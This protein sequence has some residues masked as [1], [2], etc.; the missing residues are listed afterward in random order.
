[1]NCS[2]P[3]SPVLHCLP[4]F[5][6]ED[7]ILIRCQYSPNGLT[8]WVQPLGF[9]EGTSGEEAVCQC[10]RCGSD[11]WVGKIPWGR[12]WQPTPVFLPGKPHGQRHGL[13]GCSPQGHK[14]VRQGWATEHMQSL[15]KCKPD[16]R[17]PETTDLTMKCIWKWKGHK[18]AK[19]VF[20]R[21][22]VAEFTVSNC[23]THNKATAV[24]TACSG[25]KDW[26]T[27]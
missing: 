3:A 27:G 25:G 1:M 11:P 4:E 19:R 14:G 7:S 21:N 15:S 5:V 24:K 12:A 23:K 26:H 8:D 6:G 22:K 20:Q 2:T 17:G 9:P 13:M 10:R 18:I 16:L